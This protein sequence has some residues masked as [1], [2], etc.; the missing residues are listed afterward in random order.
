MTEEGQGVIVLKDNKKETINKEENKNEI[1]S[2]VD[3]NNYDQEVLD[4]KGNLKTSS[5]K[6]E[7]LE[8]NKNDIY[9]LSSEA[10]EKLG[11][12]PCQICQSNN[13]SIFIPENVYQ[14]PNQEE[15]PQDKTIENENQVPKTTEGDYIKPVKNQ[16]IFLPIIICKQNHQTCLICNK[17]PHINT[18]C[19]KK[20][21]D[22]HNAVLKLNFIKEKFPQKSNIIESMKQTLCSPFIETNE[23]S[24]CTCKCCCKC[25]GI[26]ILIF[27]WTI[28]T[29]ILGAV[30]IIIIGL[31]LGF[32]V[33]C[34][35]YHFCYSACCTT[36]TREYD[37]GDHILRVTTHYEGREIQNKKEA[38][39]DAEDLNECCAGGLYCTFS[40]ISWG[41]K[42]ICELRD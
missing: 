25:F 28:I 30:G 7:Q 35:L 2:K 15:K 23:E 37:K 3:I 26:S 8:F 31:Y 19:I 27:I 29:I 9:E 22:Y 40:L 20:N 4:S 24:C 33:L 13:Y 16:N 39:R 6:N 21:Y 42:K 1:K 17:S 10:I 5:P 32:Q 14:V 38:A 18:L 34:C 36:E 12:S 11:I 41:Y